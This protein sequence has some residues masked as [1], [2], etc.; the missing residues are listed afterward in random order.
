[1]C[2]VLENLIL[3]FCNK[4]YLLY[5]RYQLLLN[6][7]FD[8]F[9]CTEIA[10]D[11]IYLIDDRITSPHNSLQTSISPACNLAKSATFHTREVF[12][13]PSFLI[14]YITFLHKTV[15]VASLVFSLLFH[16]LLH[17]NFSCVF[18]SVFN[19]P[20]IMCIIRN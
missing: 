3:V 8:H 1:M 12:A 16:F 20:Y 2:V 7:V 17:Y 18:N 14:F 19:I 9:G 6:L 5:V 15:V 10:I 4:L 13:K 11:F